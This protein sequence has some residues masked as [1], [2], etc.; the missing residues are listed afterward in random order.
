MKKEGCS[1]YTLLL[2][3]LIFQNFLRKREKRSEK[4]EVK[5]QK[6][7]EEEK[8]ITYRNKFFNLN[9]V[10]KKSAGQNHLLLPNFQKTE[11]DF[12]PTG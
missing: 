11:Q 5:Q 7:K 3:A 4:E 6:K 2:Q 12:L 8:M 9:K 1:C 10:K